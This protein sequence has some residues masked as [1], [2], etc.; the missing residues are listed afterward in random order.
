M[1][2][3]YCFSLESLLNIE[4]SM[5]SKVVK[6]NTIRLPSHRNKMLSLDFTLFPRFHFNFVYSWYSPVH[7]FLLYLFI[8]NKQD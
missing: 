1:I 3:T 6:D 7:P 8:S 2:I 5:V 4:L